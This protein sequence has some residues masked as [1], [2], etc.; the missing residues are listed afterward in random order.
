VPHEIDMR[1]LLTRNWFLILLSTIVL[2]VGIT[3]TVL[4]AHAFWFAVAGSLLTGLGAVAACRKFIR[5]GFA[6]ARASNLPVSGGAILPTEEDMDHAHQANL[7]DRAS[8][9][10]SALIVVGTPLQI[11]GYLMSA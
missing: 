11:I 3:L 4:F 7:D 1:K 9:L 10:A 6:E 2:G 8:I 5:L